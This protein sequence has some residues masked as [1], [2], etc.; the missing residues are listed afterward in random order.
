MTA[1]HC[2][3]DPAVKGREVSEPGRGPFE[4]LPVTKMTSKRQPI[5]WREARKTAY[6]RV[7]KR[8]PRSVST[9]RARDTLPSRLRAI[10]E[11]WLP[12]RDDQPYTGKGN[13][14]HRLTQPLTQMG[15][16]EEVARA[17]Y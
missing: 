6:H 10:V 8:A 13:V 9:E 16:Q 12:Q 11:Q 4:R 17:A 7:A 14:A 3:I 2:K 1:P 5:V 15:T